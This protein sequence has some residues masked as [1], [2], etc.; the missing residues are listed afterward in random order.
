MS[1]DELTKRE[2]ERI[3][4]TLNNVGRRAR[5]VSWN[6]PQAQLLAGGPLG[7]IGRSQASTIKSLQEQIREDERKQ[8]PSPSPPS[9]SPS[10]S[11]SPTPQHYNG[12]S[13]FTTLE[14]DT[15]EKDRKL[16]LEEERL[17]RWMNKGDS[18][19]SAN[20]SKLE[21]DNIKTTE[22]K[23]AISID[24]AS[25]HLSAASAARAGLSGVN[26]LVAR[27]Q[28]QL[29]LASKAYR[30][31]KVDDVVKN[32][33]NVALIAKSIAETLSN[34]AEILQHANILESTVASLRVSESPEHLNEVAANLGLLFVHVLGVLSPN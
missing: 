32:S 19:F 4:R 9:P 18:R 27:L 33:F 26:E 23:R 24:S 17:E 7:S 1:Q 6:V 2:E 31:K 15:A 29:F 34:D 11:P 10:P 22:R 28:D 8:T 16:K 12:A 21:T 25:E 5:P 14:E 20:A 13:Q 3:N 30:Q